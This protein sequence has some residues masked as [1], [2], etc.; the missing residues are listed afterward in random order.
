[1]SPL[2][3]TRPLVLWAAAL[4]AKN[5]RVTVP[6]SLAVDANPDHP[7]Q[8]K[9]LELALAPRHDRATTSGGLVFLPVAACYVEADYEPG[10]QNPNIH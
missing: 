6:A 1:M 3:G 10:R 8:W 4:P 5:G 9:L 2:A 7:E